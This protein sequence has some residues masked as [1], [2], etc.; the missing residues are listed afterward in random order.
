MEF[1][2]TPEIFDRPYKKGD[3]RIWQA[4]KE[5][6]ERAYGEK[7]QLTPWK[8]RKDWLEQIWFRVGEKEKYQ[9]NYF[10]ARSIEEKVLRFGFTIER[11]TPNEAEKE[12]LTHIEWEMFE[13]LLRNDPDFRGEFDRLLN[14]GG[15]EAWLSR[16]SDETKHQRVKDADDL[17]KSLQDL[18]PDEGFTLDLFRSLSKGQALELGEGV[19]DQIVEAMLATSALYNRITGPQI[20]IA[21]IA[22]S[23]NGWKGWSNE[24]EQNAK[25]SGFGFVKEYGFGHEWWNFN[26]ELSRNS[27][28]WVYGYAEKI[29]RRFQ[30]ALV[31][32]VSRNYKNGK[33]Y[34][35]GIYGGAETRS[36]SDSDEFDRAEKDLPYDFKRKRPDEAKLSCSIRGLKD[37]SIGF[38]PE[39]PEITAADL[40]WKRFGQAIF[41]KADLVRVKCLVERA[42]EHYQ[43]MD[44]DPE[45]QDIVQ[46]LNTIARRYFSN[47]E[48]LSTRVWKIAP[49]KGAHLW[50][51]C[52]ER[53]CIVLGWPEVEQLLENGDYRCFKTKE[54]MRQKFEEV[55]EEAEGKGG[56]KS[57]WPF[58]HEITVGDIVVA[59]KGVKE[60]VGIGIITSDYLPPNDPLNPSQDKEHRQA[61]LVKWVITEPVEIKGWQFTQTTISQ[62]FNDRWEYIKAAYK[63]QRGI[64]VDAEIEKAIKGNLMNY[65]AAKGYQFTRKQIST[66]Y[67]A[68]KTKGFVIL[69]GLSGTGKTK[70]ALLFAELLCEHCRKRTDVRRDEDKCIHLFLS[71]RPDWR[72][73]KALLGYYNPL[74]ERYESTPLLRL[75]LRAKTNYEENGAHAMP[76]FVILDEMNLAHVEYYLA[77]FLSVLES[78]RSDGGWTREPLRLH[79]F[80][81]AVKDQEDDEVPP[82]LHLPPNLYIIGTVN[83]DETT[84]TFSPKVLDRAFTIEFREVNFSDYNPEGGDDGEADRIANNIRETILSDLRNNGKFC[85]EASD[86]GA[87]RRALN[88]LGGYKGTLTELNDL[89]YPYDLHFGYR[90]LDEI[91]L[92][93]KHATN[94]PEEV[95]D[96][97]DEGTIDHA[98]LMKVLPKFHGPMQKLKMP[99]W[100]I[101]NWC[102]K[103]DADASAGEGQ[104]ALPQVVWQKITGDGKEPSANE[105]AEQ[106]CAFDE[107]KFRF[108]NTA[109]KALQMLR[110]LYETGFTSFAG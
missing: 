72:D 51:M 40:G 22:W 23:S 83:V 61:R 85:A 96:L 30:D 55:F 20:Y 77:D 18:R 43:K 49:G 44:D 59:N 105:I 73:G 38:K 11:P 15:F 33:F 6:L 54:E 32:F 99:L 75:L 110:Q 53:K 109:R 65:F 60:V 66:F 104:S 24:D 45:A 57:V 5:Q 74:T 46:V 69:S 64:D 93:F 103:E 67:A 4:I 87:I 36:E 76:Y 25:Q 106:L 62:V 84:Y 3:P 16:W 78:G 70:L 27:E 9:A 39:Y 101:I 12:E 68:L 90:V 95:G 50:E 56:W 21:N 17:I 29:T 80:V 41:R 91:A 89:L 42:I 7:V 2:L 13:L 52:R 35:V 37:L 26:F 107:A 108:P 79:S 58:V 71:V 10:L 48:D 47:I 86:K 82:T 100:R 88:D 92:F 102:L 81:S 19:V 94:L 28:K 1:I 14:E 31:L 97:D 8:P 34:F 98:V 63:E